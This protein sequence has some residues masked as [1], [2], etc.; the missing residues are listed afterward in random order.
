MNT[1]SW[2]VQLSPWQACFF[3]PRSQLVSGGV[4]IQTQAAQVAQIS[5]HVYSNITPP[6]YTVQK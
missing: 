1:G 3:L 2:K 6:L 4:A 5:A